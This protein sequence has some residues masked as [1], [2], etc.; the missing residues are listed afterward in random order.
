MRKCPK[1]GKLY[2]NDALRCCNFDRRCRAA[3]ELV[4]EPLPG[5]EAEPEGKPGPEAKPEFRGRADEIIDALTKFGPMA[6]KELAEELGLT[7][8][9]IVRLVSQMGR[10]GVNLKREGRPRKVSLG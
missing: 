3:T 6:Y 10:D 2:P 5:P 8:K 7:Y 1:C 9:R 4:F